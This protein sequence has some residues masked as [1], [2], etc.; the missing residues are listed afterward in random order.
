MKSNYKIYDFE[1]SRERIDNILK[2]EDKFFEEVDKIPSRDKL[3][4]NNGFYVNKTSALFVDIRESSKL[5]TKYKRPVL[6]RIYR[7]YISE[8][9]AVINGDI[10]CAEININ[11]DC[12]WGVFDAQYQNQINSVFSTAAEISSVIDTLNCKYKKK[13]IDPLVVGIGLAFGRVLMIKA[14]YSGSSLNDVV[15]MGEVVNE[16]S[17][18]C[19]Y[20]NKTWNDREIM[21]SSVF[22]NNLNDHNKELLQWN[23]NRGCYH[24]N[25]VN[26]GMNNWIDENCK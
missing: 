3:T 6:A 17:N 1:K 11:G 10:N 18:L 23:S 24:G 4:F 5:P 2:T 22:R 12:V 13:G 9:V 25:V 14:G 21:V 7:P 20:G 15:W 16:S 19:A 8:V 26:T